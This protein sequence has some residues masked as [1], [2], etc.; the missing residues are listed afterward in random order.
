L[1]LM[2]VPTCLVWRWFI[3]PVQRG[4]GHKGIPRSMKKLY[5]VPISANRGVV[6]HERP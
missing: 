4:S 1:L 3:D 2:G 6:Q 5:I